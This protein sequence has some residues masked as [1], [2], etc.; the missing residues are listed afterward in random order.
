MSCP[1]NYWVWLTS[2]HETLGPSFNKA[3][4][5]SRV[6]IGLFRR[7]RFR[8]SRQHADF[9][10]SALFDICCG[11]EVRDFDGSATLVLPGIPR[12]AHSD[13]SIGAQGPHLVDL[14]FD[15]IETCL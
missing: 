5:T 6:Q 1:P 11:P 3:S 9:P 2:L 12:L 7:R 13:G 15:V 10:F 14:R 8:K 4:A